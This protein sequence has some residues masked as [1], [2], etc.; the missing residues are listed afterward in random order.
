MILKENDEV[1]YDA[2]V[3]MVIIMRPKRFVGC[4]GWFK[5]ENATSSKD[6]VRSSKDEKM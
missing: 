4:L 1:K 3:R 2:R 6:G 5:C